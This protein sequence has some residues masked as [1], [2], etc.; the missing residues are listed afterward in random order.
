[1]CAIATHTHTHIGA[2][3]LDCPVSTLNATKFSKQE[4]TQRVAQKCT[5]SS[6]CVFELRQ[7]LPTFRLIFTPRKGAQRAVCAPVRGGEI[8]WNMQALMTSCVHGN[9]CI[10][11]NSNEVSKLRHNKSTTPIPP[12]FLKL[13]NGCR[14]AWLGVHPP[15]HQSLYQR[16]TV[17]ERIDAFQVFP[18][19]PLPSALS[20]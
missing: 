17:H 10:E 11:H 13:R 20:T 4:R 1:M 14:T 16:C 6:F 3:V 2:V 18:P 12:F 8:R 15:V 7:L 19:P 5:T 9:M